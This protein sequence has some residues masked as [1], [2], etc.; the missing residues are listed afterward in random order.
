M[1]VK[2]LCYSALCAALLCILAPVSVP[3]SSLPLT[4]SLFAVLLVSAILPTRLALSSV[5]CYVV[6][7]AVGLPVFAGFI[8]GFQVLAGPTGGFII[9]YIPVAFIVSLFRKKPIKRLVSMV[10]STI[11]CYIFG[12]LW[13]FISTSSPF[14]PTLG[15]IML[16]CALPDAVKIISASLLAGAVGTRITA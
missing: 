5:L 16:I 15:A 9:G 2:S 8:G 7:G 1:K 10:L 4:L 6:L 11:L 14:I 13:L 12:A 3:T